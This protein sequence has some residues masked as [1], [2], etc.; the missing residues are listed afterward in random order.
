MKNP[1]PKDIFKWDNQEVRKIREGRFHEH[2]FNIWENCRQ[3]FLKIIDEEFE[4]LKIQRERRSEDED[5]VD[6]RNFAITTLLRVKECMDS[7][8]DNHAPNSPQT[9]DEMLDSSESVK[10]S[11]RSSYS[12]AS[13]GVPSQPADTQTRNPQGKTNGGKNEN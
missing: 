13:S 9:K 2:C 5:Y 3:D 12:N 8:R 4:E 7:E 1:Y 11:R 6:K 10:N